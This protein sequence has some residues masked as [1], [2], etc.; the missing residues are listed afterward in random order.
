VVVWE[1]IFETYDN[2][3]LIV[4]RWMQEGNHKCCK[5]VFLQYVESSQYS[6]DYMMKVLGHSLA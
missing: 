5:A 1:R 3:K 6:G 4:E 2:M